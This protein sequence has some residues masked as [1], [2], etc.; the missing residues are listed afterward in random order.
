VTIA[1]PRI[2]L[3]VALQPMTVKGAEG[4]FA[5]RAVATARDGRSF[6]C[7]SATLQPDQRPALEARRIALAVEA[8]M[9]AGA[10]LG[11]A[12]LVVPIGAASGRIGALLDSLAGTAA[13]AGLA[14]D[15]LVVAIDADDRGNP[16][17]AVALAEACAVRGLAIAL[18]RFAAGPLSLRLLTRFVPRFVTLDPSLV[19]N[20]D[21]S[22][23]RRLIAEGVLRLTRRL[24]VTVVARGAESRGEH[25]ALA[26]M[27]IRHFHA[28]TAT[29]A[30]YLA[31][32][33]PRSP[34]ADH[35]RLAHHQRLT[36]P[37]PV[38]AM[39]VQYALAV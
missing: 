12:L 35:R 30:A 1:T 27:G 34:S 22:M 23:S 11:D 6:A 14:L 3:T 25:A 17:C 28:E 39:P 37:A 31:R 36:V 10:T 18:D 2:D 29:P 15:R 33:E 26:D 7:V 16:E 4:A 24:G 9:E 38:A 19:R 32:R 8:A 21:A 20:I 5:W 13:A